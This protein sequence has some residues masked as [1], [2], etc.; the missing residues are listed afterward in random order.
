MSYIL[1]ALKKSEKERGKNQEKNSSSRTVIYPGYTKSEKPSN[2]KYIYIAITTIVFSLITYLLTAYLMTQPEKA[3]NDLSKG[4]SVNQQHSAARDSDHTQPDKQ[5]VVS[6]QTVNQQESSAPGVQENRSVVQQQPAT[7]N[8]YPDY[9]ELPQ[10]IKNS[11]PAFTIA[12]HTYSDQPDQ[13]MLILNNTI[14]KE[15]QAIGNGLRLDEIT[16]NG[17]ILRYNDIVFGVNAGQ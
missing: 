12:G 14:V 6:S 15:G 9:N 5:N 10:Q 8:I 17:A 7:E 1:E 3:D 13:R 4:N 2:R 11:I 16:W